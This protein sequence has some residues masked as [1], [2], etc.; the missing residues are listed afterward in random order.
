MALPPTF[1]SSRVRCRVHRIFKCRRRN[2]MQFGIN[3]IDDFD[4]KGKTVLCRI[5]I[6]QPVDCEKGTL[7]STARIEACTPT[8]KELSDKGAKLVLM[9]HQGSDIE[10]KNYYTTEPHSKVL[11]KLLGKDVKFIP[12]VCG[13]AAIEAI[14]G[15]NDGEIL[16]LDNVRF[17]A[18]EQT[19]FEKNLK[20]THEEQA[21]TLL[22]RKL[23]PLADL[24]ICD[25]FAAAHRDQPSLCGFEQVLPSAMGRL[26]E[27]EYRILSQL[28]EAPKHP[29]TF[30]LGGAKVADA[31]MMMRTVLESGVADK[32]LTG[33]LVANIMLAATGSNIGRGSLDF[34][35]KSGYSEYIEVAKELYAAFGSHIVLPKDL[36]FVENGKRVEVKVGEVPADAG[37]LDIGTETAEKY[38]E[39]IRASETVFVNGP[40]GVFEEA[41]TESGT[42]MV[43]DALGDTRAFTVVGGGDSI[44]AT[45]KYGKKEQIDYICT[46]GGSLIRFLSGKELPVV[47]ALK[48]A[49]GKD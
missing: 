21:K 3:T 28:M 12:D 44:T 13:P 30:V 4:V 26:F 6:N 33:G 23:A 31:F 8:L 32:I 15:L 35:E 9:A 36:A 20:L 29:C 43:W 7:K 39:I 37:V 18:E 14:K 16:L 25:A 27:K 22:V 45:T 10:Y 5:D 19:L 11:T 42:K 47:H 48:A 49:A 41:P 24:Y 1:Y 40:M 34:I 46:G 2:A 38:Q 17:L